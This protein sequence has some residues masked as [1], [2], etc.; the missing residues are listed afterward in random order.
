MGDAAGAGQLGSD[1]AALEVEYQG[2]VVGYF[3]FGDDL[4]PSDSGGL[5]HQQITG[6]PEWF[7]IAGS[8]GVGVPHQIDQP[9]PREDLERLAVGQHVEVA[10]HHCQV[11]VLAYAGDKVREPFGL[12]LPSRSVALPT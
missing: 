3:G 11:A 2:A 10:A 8:P 9:E 7:G 4:E 1:N 6:M 12:R 5:G